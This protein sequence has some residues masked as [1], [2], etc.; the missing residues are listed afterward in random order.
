MESKLILED[1]S[2]TVTDS[3]VGCQF[4]LVPKY[5]GFYKLGGNQ[6]LRISQEKKPCWFHRKMMKWCLSFEWFDGPAV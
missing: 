6:G 2:I 4:Q 1:K 3:A 5:V